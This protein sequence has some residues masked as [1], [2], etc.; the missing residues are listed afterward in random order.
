MKAKIK[1]LL[2]VYHYEVS[3]TTKNKNRVYN[4]EKYKMINIINIK[5]IIES[6]NYEIDKYN[7]FYIYEP[8]L[9]IVMSLDIGN[10]I[11]DHY[12]AKYILIP[13]LDKYLDIRNVASRKNMGMSYGIKLLKKYIELNKKYDNLYVLKI[14][15]K[16]YLGDGFK[17]TYSSD[18]K[19]K[20]ASGKIVT[21]KKTKMPDDLV[22]LENGDRK[23]YCSIS[24]K[25]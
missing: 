5:N 21:Y 4:F 1:D 19:I 11:I 13:K 10:R 23:Y 3:K 18:A 2:D 7:I 20:Y 15:I 17:M 25:K 6:S 9:R 14:D 22:T 8:K 24:Y 16:K 12:V